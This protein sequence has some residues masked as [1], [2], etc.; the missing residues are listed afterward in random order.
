MGASMSGLR[1]HPGGRAGDG[2]ALVLSER[3]RELGLPQGRLKTGTPPRIDGRSVDFSKLI[4]QP[5]DTDPVPVFSFMG[6]ADQHPR[7]VCLLDHAH[8]RAH[9]RDHPQGLRPQPDVHRRDRR[10]RARATAPA[11]KTR[12]IVLPRKLATRSSWSQKGS[13]RTRSTRTASRP[14]CLSTC[15]GTPCARWWAWSRPTSCARAMRSST[16]TSTQGPSRQTFETQ[17]IAGLYF[18]GQIN[19]TTGYEEAAAQGLHAGTNAALAVLGRE[20]WLPRRDEAYL[21]VLVDDL[22][23]KGVSEPY[24]MFTSRAEHRLHLR[25]DNADLRLTERG[26]ELGLVD[27]ARWAP[28]TAS[29]TRWRVRPRGSSP[30]GCTPGSWTRSWRSGPSASRSSMSTAWLS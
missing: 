27:D 7:Q 13:T 14:R 23:T 2:P 3:L 4:E 9:A 19:G 1:N 22:I 24:R 10:R 5:G 18:A 25:E 21:G 17:A 16:T 12:S 8:Q 29:G 28:S 11:S 30:P 20:P 15:S 26:R 6:R